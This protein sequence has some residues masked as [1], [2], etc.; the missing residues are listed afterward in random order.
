MTTSGIIDSPEREEK[1][2]FDFVPL[3]TAI[4]L[5]GVTYIMVYGFIHFTGMRME[6]F[7][8]AVFVGPDFEIKVL[9]FY[10]IPFFIVMSVYLVSLTGL[11][12]TNYSE[13]VVHYLSLLICFML[14]NILFFAYHSL[15]EFAESVFGDAHVKS[16][17]SVTG[18]FFRWF[19]VFIPAIYLLTMTIS[20]F[21][22]HG[23]R[24]YYCVAISIVLAILL[25][26][27][28]ILFRQK[29]DTIG[30][31]NIFIACCAF[32]AGL[33]INKKQAPA[34]PIKKGL[35]AL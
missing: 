28:L 35:N 33:M 6:N 27:F 10:L 29:F 21:I 8:M 18:S 7:G 31:F 5:G 1:P 23:F 30:V 24:F 11:F 13:M 19:L 9:S 4:L 22:T 32:G 25:A 14:M 3:I 2:G 17:F 15:F 26:A 34:R 20:I 12:D 16:E